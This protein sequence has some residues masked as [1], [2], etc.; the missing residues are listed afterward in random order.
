MRAQTRYVRM[1]PLEEAPFHTDCLTS[2]YYI[3]KKTFG[4][5]IPLTYVGDMPRTLHSGGEWRFLR[6]DVRSIQCGDICF[7]KR[8]TEPKLI[9]HAALFLGPDEVFHCKRDEGAVVENYSSFCS[10]FE[11]KLTDTQIHYID[12]RN[13]ELREKYKDK[14]LIEHQNMMLE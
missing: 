7:V 12:P 2:I 14:F 10:I 6:A 13:R 9:A 11:Q 5:D 1:A 3:F 8:I 4:I